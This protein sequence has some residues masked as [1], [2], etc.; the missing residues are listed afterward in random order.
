MVAGNGGPAA[1]L[2][3][4]LAVCSLLAA[5]HTVC[6]DNT[7]IDFDRLDDKARRFYAH[8]EWES[9]LAMYELML[10][11][12]PADCPTYSHAITVNGVLRRPDRQMKL[13]EQTE[14]NGISLDSLFSRVRTEAYALGKPAVYEELLVLIKKNQP[15]LRRSVDLR[16][17]HYYDSRNDVPN[18]LALGDSLLSVNP[19]DV[20]SLGVK[21]RA[22]LLSGDLEGCVATN[23]RLLRVDSLNFKALLDVGMIR[24]R[25]FDRERLSLDSPE[26]AEAREYLQRAFAVQP[27]P[28]VKELLARLKPA[29]R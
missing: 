21:A 16:L 12:R 17:I 6:A 10:M 1:W 4:I 14:H 29:M 20:Y 25:Q 23:K 3:R 18:M 13:V 22:H 7:G 5:C 27:T 8:E 24:F 15:W 28:Y 9:A 2:C 19:D 26:A 11:E